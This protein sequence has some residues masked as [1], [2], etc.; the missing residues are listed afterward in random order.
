MTDPQGWFLASHALDHHETV[1]TLATVTPESI[2][3][4]DDPAARLTLAEHL[5]TEL[6]RAGYGLVRLTPEP[7]LTHDLTA[8][9]DA[10][11]AEEAATSWFGREE[12]K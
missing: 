5:A 4:A 12:D 7:T 9:V 6:G 3:Y 11:L 8:Q 1:T 2:A 10:H